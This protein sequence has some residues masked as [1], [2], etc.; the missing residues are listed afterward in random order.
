MAVIEDRLSPRVEAGFS[1]IPGRFTRIRALS[2]GRERRNGNWAQ[3]R[4]RYTSA[5]ASFTRAQRAEILNLV[6]AAEG[7][8]YAWL[9]KDWNDYAVEGQALAAA[10]GTNP[11]QLVK[12]YTFGSRTFTRTITRPV[13]ST[14]TVYDAG[15]AKAGT[16]DATTGLFTPA[17]A[18][19]GGTITADFEFDVPVRFATDDIEFVLPHR[20][21]AEVNV[22]LIEVRGE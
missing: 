11:V 3:P 8:L 12:T 7:S 15:V 10:T 17:V 19:S 20:E 22:E 16:L 6:H 18:W 4:H 1:A 13:A 21:V 14:T 9:F 2:N 5:Y